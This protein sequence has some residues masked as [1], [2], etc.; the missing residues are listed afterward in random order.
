VS[1]VVINTSRR[2]ARIDPTAR[3][4]PACIAKTFSVCGD[5]WLR[6][7]RMAFTHRG[8]TWKL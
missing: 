8:S 2:L 1:I 5:L 3:L 6:T 4:I 7:R